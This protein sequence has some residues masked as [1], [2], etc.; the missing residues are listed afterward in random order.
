MFFSEE[1]ENNLKS[2]IG[3]STILDTIVIIRLVD[4]KPDWYRFYISDKYMLPKN[5][6]VNEFFVYDFHKDT[7]WFKICM[8]FDAVR[9]K[10]T[11]FKNLDPTNYQIAVN[12]A[13]GKGP[14][15]ND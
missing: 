14:Q 11:L 2:V 8:V 1:I 9:Y 15:Y 7:P 4:F 5:G 13:T 3:Y 6:I 12:R 10:C